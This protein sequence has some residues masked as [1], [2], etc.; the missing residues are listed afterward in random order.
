M[1]FLA[2]SRSFLMAW[3]NE[4]LSS[5]RSTASSEAAAIVTA[6]ARIRPPEAPPSEFSLDKFGAVHRTLRVPEHTAVC[7]EKPVGAALYVEEPGPIAPDG[8]PVCSDLTVERPNRT[9]VL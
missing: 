6:Q 9:I 2:G 5:L 3:T 7:H 8:P 4:R 1:V